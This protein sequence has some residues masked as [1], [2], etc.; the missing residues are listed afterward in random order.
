MLEG[1]TLLRVVSFSFIPLWPH[2]VPLLVSYSS[3]VRARGSLLD[4]SARTKVRKL[5]LYLGFRLLQLKL[6]GVLAEEGEDGREVFEADV[7]E[8]LVLGRDLH[9]HV[10]ELVVHGG[11]GTKVD[12]STS[13]I[14]S[15]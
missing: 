3:S 10:L 11:V 13:E 15:I 9:L 2:S 4:L 7:L 6:L 14:K 8:H 5:P 12:C 1:I